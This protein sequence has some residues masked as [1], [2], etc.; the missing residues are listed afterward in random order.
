LLAVLVL[1]AAMPAFGMP[2][3]HMVVTDA[4]EHRPIAGANV[5]F[6]ARAR[7][8][9]LS[10][11]GGRVATLFLAEAIS[12]ANGNVDFAEQKVPFAP[13]LF[14]TNYEPPL[15]LVYKPG[16]SVN[17][18]H[19]ELRAPDRGLV[20][21]WDHN[22]ETLKMQ[23]ANTEQER[24]E[25]IYW[26]QEYAWEAYRAATPCSW[27]SIPQILVALES[28]SSKWAERNPPAARRS[29]RSWERGPV[30]TLVDEEAEQ[31]AKGCGSPREFFQPYFRTAIPSAGGAPGAPPIVI[32]APPDSVM[33]PAVSPQR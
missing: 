21:R 3:I 17:L 22:G 1:P 29:W 11:H 14:N 12:D 6:F 2:A 23:H 4:E 31:I 7:E 25:A 26:S 18:V 19:N 10:G 24:G 27:K 16:Y 32:S 8:G 33:R 20:A 13:F 28:E 30:S 15:L 9:T 5:L